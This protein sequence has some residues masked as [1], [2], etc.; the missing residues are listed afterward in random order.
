MIQA[1]RGRAGGARQTAER[2][3]AVKAGGVGA[4][5]DQGAAWAKQPLRRG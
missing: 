1:H 3:G 5:A 2:V 4:K